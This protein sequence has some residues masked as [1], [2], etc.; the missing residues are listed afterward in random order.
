[1]VAADWSSV[2]TWWLSQMTADLSKFNA[3]NA[4]CADYE[5]EWA[6]KASTGSDADIQF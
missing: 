5:K 2:S 1:M 4:K 3:Y 6:A